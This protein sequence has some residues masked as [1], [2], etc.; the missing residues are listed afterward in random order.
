MDQKGID[1]GDYVLVRPQPNARQNDIVVA[2]IDNLEDHR[3]GVSLKLFQQKTDKITLKPCSNNPS[4][5]PMKFDLPAQRL[6]RGI[7]LA[8][9]KP[10]AYFA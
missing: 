8:V 3:E 7:A 6:V 1:D 10:I 9:F 5:Q 4:H 2:E